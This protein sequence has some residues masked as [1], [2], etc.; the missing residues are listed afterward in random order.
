MIQ[1]GA[2]LPALST[3]KNAPT[4]VDDEIFCSEMSL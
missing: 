3:V 2:L 1:V 4:Q